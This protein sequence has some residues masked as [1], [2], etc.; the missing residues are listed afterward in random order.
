MGKHDAPAINDICRISAGTEVKGS[1]VSKSDIRIDG[2]FDG[3][4][5]TGGKLVLGEHANIKGNIV[6][7]SADIWGT[8]DGEL[9]V[10]EAANF[11]SSASFTGNLKTGRIS[12]E[13]GAKFNGNCAIAE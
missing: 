4:L 10:K 8:I 6:C 3:E 11:K 7:N 13:L 1:L 9:T 2:C 12:I 5:T